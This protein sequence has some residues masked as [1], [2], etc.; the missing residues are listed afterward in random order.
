VK[1]SG[2]ATQFLKAD[3]SSDSTSYLP[4]VISGTA[5][6]VP[7]HQGTASTWSLGTGFMDLVPVQITKAVT[8]SGIACRVTTAGQAT[9]VIRM[10]IFNS[11]ANFQ[12]SSLLL[13]AGT[14]SSST[15]GTKEITISQALSPGVYW[16]AVVG[17]VAANHIIQSQT[18]VY[19]PL[20]QTT[21]FETTNGLGAY[22]QSGVTAALPSTITLS[23]LST[24]KWQAAIKIKVT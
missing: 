15:T 4:T 3:G 5:V 18:G 20:I 23:G 2:T 21:A 24:Q 8:A 19:V 14:I 22:E 11:D 13:D 12:P 16:L 10:G 1:T 9:S 7:T 17:Q 6:Y